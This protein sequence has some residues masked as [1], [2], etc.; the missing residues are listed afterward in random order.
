MTRTIIH[1]ADA[2][3]HGKRFHPEFPSTTDF[4]PNGHKD[5]VDWRVLFNEMVDLDINYVFLKYDNMCNKMVEEFGIMHKV[6]VGNI[7][8]DED[9]VRFGG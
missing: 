5:D 3:P 1:I 2:P 7:D 9:R 8:A 4:Y 6:S